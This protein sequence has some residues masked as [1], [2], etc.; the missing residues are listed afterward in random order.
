VGNGIEVIQN[1]LIFGVEVEDDELRVDI[2]GGADCVC[3]TL[4][5]TFTDARERQERADLLGRWRDLGTPV[6]YV[7]RDGS[8][9]L[10]DELALLSDALG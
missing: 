9:A 6:T 8:A 2:Y 5:Y 3:G 1:L 7:R 10:M 4:I